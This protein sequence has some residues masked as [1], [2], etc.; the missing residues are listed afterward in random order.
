MHQVKKSPL[1]LVRVRI[2]VSQSPTLPGQVGLVSFGHFLKGERVIDVDDFGDES[3]YS[4]DDF[5]QLDIAT[6]RKVLDFCIGDKGG[7]FAPENLNNLPESWYMN[8]S[9]SPN[10]GFDADDNAVALKDILTGDELVFDYA[11]AEANPTFSFDC[12]CGATTCRGRITGNDWRDLPNISDRY[13]K[14][15]SMI[16]GLIEKMHEYEVNPSD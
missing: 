4:W 9:C 6:Q 7:F 2:G 16:R 11:F 12:Q 5:S 10:I 15:T 14:S 3:Y 13:L 8:H 1:E